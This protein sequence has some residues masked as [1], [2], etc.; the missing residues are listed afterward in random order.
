[1]RP[2]RHWLVALALL[3]LIW[4]GVA[5]VMRQTDDQVSW[6]GKVIGLVETAPWLE[7]GRVSGDE[8]RLYLNRVILQFNRLGFAQRR[9]LRDDGRESLDRFFA[10]LTVEEQKLYVD[11]TVEPCLEFL[12]A[13]LKRVSVEERK[14]LVTRMRGDLRSLSADG[15]RLDGEEREFLELMIAEDPV[16]FLREAPTRVKLELAPALEEMQA[17]LQGF[18]R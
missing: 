9:R 8:R 17:R 18:R 11:R 13:G 12:E 4:G 10:S 1:M 3:V 15:G 14:R 5:V 7:G 2:S 16:L 6:P